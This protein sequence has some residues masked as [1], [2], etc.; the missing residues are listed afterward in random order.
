MKPYISREHR[1]MLLLGIALLW[2]G[3]AA[4][5][6]LLGPDPEVAKEHPWVVQPIRPE[7]KEY[8]C[9]KLGLPPTHPV[10]QADKDV[11]TKDLLPVLQQRFPTGQTL[12][13]EVAEVL[14]GYPVQVEETKSPNGTVVSLRYNYLLTEFDGFCIEI[15][16]RDP[17]SGIVSRIYSSNPSGS[18]P[19]SDTCTSTEVREQPRPWLK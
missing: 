2:S 4:S 19:T 13:S 11:L 6:A 12:Y 3:V 1:R 5:C 16:V 8:F 10:C 17:Q 14:K 15:E 9:A 18:G 7:T